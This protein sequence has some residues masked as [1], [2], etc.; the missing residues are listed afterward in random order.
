MATVLNWRELETHAPIL[1]SLPADTRR[2]ARSIE[3]RR[4]EKLFSIGD[5]PAGLYFVISGEVRLSRISATGQQ[6]TLQRSR[7]GFLA[8][9]SL[10]QARHHCDAVATKES[11]LLLVPR[12]SFESALADDHFQHKWV[13]HLAREL[14]RV[15][16]QA[17]RLS[18][19]TTEE[20]IIHFIETEGNGKEVLLIGTRKEW[21][22]DLGV[23]HEALYRTLARMQ[24]FGK[25]EIEGSIVRIGRS[26]SSHHP[27]GHLLRRR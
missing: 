27:E 7:G 24:K 11:Q 14:S 25:V 15:R 9:A 13:L 1:V 18:L 6:I 2:Q 17:E 21:A 19:N 16:A 4:S 5:R 22:A 3:L 20:R 8:E 10:D 12:K 23:S 26:R